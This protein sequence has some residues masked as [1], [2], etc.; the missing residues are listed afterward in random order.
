M[1]LHTFFASLAGRDVGT[2][3]ATLT[4]GETGARLPLAFH[5]AMLA[6]LTRS[7]MP[8]SG[9]AFKMPS[10]S[11]TLGNR[12]F[13]GTMFSRVHRLAR[14]NDDARLRGWRDIARSRL[15]C[16]NPPAIVRR[17]GAARSRAHRLCM[18]CRS[19][20]TA[21]GLLA[22]AHAAQLA[23]DDVQPNPPAQ[24][25][26]R[27]EIIAATLRTARE[28]VDRELPQLTE[29]T[30]RADAWG[31][32]GMLYHAQNRL[33][34][35]ADA[36][37]RALA[38][39]PAARWHYLLA[40]VQGDR[41]DLD[42]AIA[43]YRRSRSAD[44]RYRLSA[45]RLGLALLARGDHRAAA[46][47]LREALALAPD[48]AA[49]HMAL[50]NAA[51]AAEDWPQARM[52]LERAAALAPD[53]GR[54]AY[55]LALAHRELGNLDQAR[56]WLARRNDIA[57]AV[58]D[59][60]LLAVAELSLSPAF[61]TAAGERAW[62][63][64]EHE[65]ALA[66]WRNAAALAP[67]DLDAGLMH[68][69]ALAQLGRSA[70]ARREVERVLGIHGNSARAWYLL[71]FLGRNDED[72]A[73]ALQ[74]ARTSLELADDETTRALLAALCM[75]AGSFDAAAAQY[76]TLAARRPEAAYYRYWLGLARLAGRD[77]PA[78]R[79]QLQAATRLQSNWGQAHIALVR[80][81]AL[82][83]DE[84]ARRKAR[85]RALELRQAKDDADTRITLAFAELGLGQRDEAQRLA[86]ADKAHADAALLLDALAANT[87]PKTPFAPN[88]AWWQPPELR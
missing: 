69:Q 75:G 26:S 60:L 4:A 5:P 34:A 39:A 32:L 84:P 43:E 42:A 23:T 30:Q 54:I 77:C 55:Q 24:N 28:A 48:S 16:R 56:L 83:G 37:R 49:V 46:V 65:D 71:A 87:V 62:E 51:A 33:A 3:G 8:A 29:A 41:G 52:M 6:G 61:F 64:G 27:S 78:A 9:A 13:S 59:P 63:R 38:A 80:A 57:P 82:C 50:G 7:P 86:N 11:S 14:S 53:A 79:P 44:P 85:D 25:L 36:Y 81:D 74:A 70:P 73:P 2:T 35:A 1:A 10:L 15:P 21:F 72:A 47:A 88:S 68:A 22:T 17:P 76:E 66:A 58:E 31:G 18:A 40:V 12:T 45:Y 20:A 19:A 67:E